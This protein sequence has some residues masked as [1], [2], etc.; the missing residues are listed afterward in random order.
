MR[1][2][3]ALLCLLPAAACQ[4]QAA[5]TAAP[6]VVQ[7]ARGE[8]SR[9]RESCASTAD[10]EPGL[11]C[12][13]QVCRNP[14]LSR[15]GEYYLTAGELAASKGDMPRANEFFTASA[16][17]FESDKIEVPPRLLCSH[18]AALRRQ[19]GDPRA[20]EQSARLLHRCMLEA[21]PGSAEFR[22]ATSELAELEALG[23]DPALLAKD[24]VADTY[25]TR[26]AWRP[27]SIAAEI[28]RTTPPPPPAKGYAAWIDGLVNT[29]ET[30]RQL[31][32]CYDLALAPSKAR[33]P[34]TVNVK[35]KGRFDEDEEIFLP[36]GTFEIETQ[37]Q[38]AK[39]AGCV[40]YA[41]VAQTSTFAE[42]ANGPSWNGSITVTLAP[43]D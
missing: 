25:I 26:P 12:V 22:R 14:V 42:K 17:A 8:A 30:R 19:T 6:P 13:E 1:L 36:G 7:P 20:A 23:L 15:R 3:A 18:G 34:V 16:L 24:K 35:Y 21:P 37:G 29:D 43:E 27:A 11:R 38:D 2:R 4:P 10:C 31:G 39:A 5:G 33:V 32:A 40:K 28:E 9:E 41:L